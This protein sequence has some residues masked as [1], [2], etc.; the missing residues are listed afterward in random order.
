MKAQS[1]KVKNKYRRWLCWVGSF[2]VLAGCSAPR[3]TAEDTDLEASTP[4]AP[5]SAAEL[6]TS[7]HAPATQANPSAKNG[8]DAV[9]SLAEETPVFA[10]VT[11]SSGIDFVHFSGAAGDYT[12]AE[13]TGAGGALFDFDNDGDLDLYLVQGAPLKPKPDTPTGADAGLARPRDRLFRNDLENTV[14]GPRVRFVDVTQQSGIQS[15]GYGMGVAT[16]DFNNDGWVDLYVTNLGSNLLL[17]NNGDSTFTDVTSAAA[18]DD[19]RWSTSAT[20]FDYDRDGWLDLFVTNYVDFTSDEKRECFSASSARDYC[21]PDAYNPVPDRLLHNRGDG[22]FEDVTLSSGVSTAFGAGLGVVAADFNGD[23]W[24]DV[25]VANDGDPNQLWINQAGSGRFEETALLAGVAL[26]RVGQAEAGMG[27]DA[28]DFDGDGDEDLF[29]THLERESDTLYVNLGQGLFEDRTIQ[30]G[31]HAP[32]LMY[33]SFGTAF[34]DYDNDGGLDLLV[35]NGAVR[36]IESLARAGDPYPLHEPNQL[37]HNNGRAGFDE[38]TSQ[39]GPAFAVSEVSRGALFGDVDNDG[40]TDVIV[41][42]NN[43]PARL[44]LNQVGNRSHWLGLRFAAKDG[45]R[46]LVQTRVEVLSPGGKSLWRRARA[47]GSYCS[48]NDPRVL[49][50][51]GASDKPRTIRVYWPDGQVEE[52]RDLAVDR[53]WV[54]RPATPIAEVQRK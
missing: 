18:A 40:D 17:R 54:V 19:P 41:C 26:N 16:G 45:G 46:D 48:A 5:V 50:G 12:L 31:L 6:G 53:Y 20:F 4:A 13:I 9:A 30:A 10:D 1:P 3:N 34:F 28:G 44:L 22:T 29:M 39:S 8:G 15:F 38:V 37:F 52:H 27:V 2:A 42:N 24:T 36:T 47:D 49:V 23:G 25:Y 21:G 43:G 14:D 33:T 51:L 35:L 7:E 32:S 11:E